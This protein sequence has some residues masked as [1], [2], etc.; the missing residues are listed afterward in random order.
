LAA[1]AFGLLGLLVLLGACTTTD[2]VVSDAQLQDDQGQG[3]GAYDTRGVS[4]TYGYNPDGTP[5][6]GQ[7]VGGPSAG[8]ASR[9]VYFDFDSV[10][11]KA[12]SRP[13]VEAHA[14]YLIASPGTLVYLEGHADERGTREYNVGLGDRRNNAVRQLMI[15][16]GVSPQQIRTISYGEERPAAAGRDDFSYAQNRRVEIAY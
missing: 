11:V 5:R 10:Q 14:N 6:S 9:I 16:M 8:Q 13:I 2:N 1:T 15:A 4:D 7:V 12:E 3:T